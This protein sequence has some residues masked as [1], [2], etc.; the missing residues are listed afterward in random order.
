MMRLLVFMLASLIPAVPSLA[1][2]VP[3]S[4][5]S[6][7]NSDKQSGGV[8]LNEASRLSANVVSLYNAKQYD[9]AIPIAK[10]VVEIRERILGNDN[11]STASAYINL[12]E[13][14]LAK[15]N[16]SAA[17]VAYEHVLGIYEKVFGVDKPENAAIIES[18]ALINY[19]K[20]NFN[21]SET[22][23]Q[24]NLAIREQALG[25]ENSD[26]AKAVMK[27]AEFYRSRR[28]YKN[29]EPLF[30]RAIAIN[31]KVLPKDDPE[32]SHTLQRYDC[33]VYESKG[34]EAARKQ[35]REFYAARRDKSAPSG[36]GEVLNGRA[37]SLPAPPY[38]GEAR[39]MRASGVVMIEVKID[40]D[41][42]VI[43]AH[44]VC[45][46]AVFGPVSVAAAR[47]ARFTPTKLSGMPVKVNGIIIY[48]FVAR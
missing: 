40:T 13:L 1:H 7:Q 23:Y 35:L 24:K 6:F 8:E 16:Y 42:K 31:D 33:F 18:L 29:A 47:N 27:L 34:V 41:G 17:E 10:R 9:E 3:T 43:D 26:V 19:V 20:G 32:I 12:A 4:W 37:L 22:L 28:E 21:K 48:N 25:L 14:Y 30:L 15:Q 44:M 45:G 2:T 38:P 11:V 46:P 5:C 36:S 39:S